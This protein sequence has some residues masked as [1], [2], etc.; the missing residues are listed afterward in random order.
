MPTP[1]A[2]SGQRAKMLS[3]IMERLEFQRIAAGIE[4][5]ECRLFARQAFKTYAGLDDEG[6]FL[7]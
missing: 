1:H 3:L 4:K 6:N 5:K 7:S 2:R